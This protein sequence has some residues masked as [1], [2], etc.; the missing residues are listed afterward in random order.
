MPRRPFSYDPRT[1]RFRGRGGRFLSARHIRDAVDKRL[2][3]A[4]REIKAVS[5][6]YRRG[7]IS[8]A[9]WMQRMRSSIRETHVMSA[10]AA[11]GGREGL[12]QR[13][14]G[15][16]GARI[17]HQYAYLRD[18]ASGLTNGTVTTDGRFLQRASS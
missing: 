8:G 12:S 1:G 10:L 5:E 9:E 18:F 11:K 13:E 14:F 7:E 4:S 17:R 3:A 16:L 15:I 6:A 2:D